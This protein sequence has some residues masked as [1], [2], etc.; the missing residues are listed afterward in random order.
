[1][2]K[3][4][5]GTLTVY[6]ESVTAKFDQGLQKAESRMQT[7]KGKIKGFGKTWTEMSNKIG[8]VVQI[9]E[10]AIGGLAAL[11]EFL[12]GDWA[13]AGE[14]VKSLPIVGGLANQMENLVNAV[15]DADDIIAQN[16]KTIAEHGKAAAAAQKKFEAYQ[17]ALEGVAKATQS[18]DDKIQLL[19]EE[20]ASGSDAA[21]ALATELARED[22]LRAIEAQMD[23]AEKLENPGRK[24]VMLAALQE[25]LDKTMR[26]FELEDKLA[27]LQ[28]DEAAAAAAKALADEAAAEAAAK[29]LSIARSMAALD[30]KRT[31][32]MGASVAGRADTFGR[33]LGTI[34]LPSM[35][36]GVEL[37]RKQLNELSAIDAEV[38]QLRADL[39]ALAA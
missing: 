37:A 18:V 11:I 20:L 25:Q 9:L 19:E 5:V 3:S 16:D 14:I 6:L 31:Q 2:A 21:A 29:R 17:K 15:T 23:A 26:M 33:P 27:K 10:A 7:F 24:K 13:K 39:K 34:K 22:A 32:A 8:L 36:T 12:K 35:S 4:D 30:K 38:K 1:M 28:A